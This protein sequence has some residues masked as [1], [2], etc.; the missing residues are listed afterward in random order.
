[1]ENVAH[2]LAGLLVARGVVAFRERREEAPASDAF[3]RW[4]AW[5]SAVANNVPDGDLILTPLSGGK[6]GYLLHHRGHTH[7][8]A[9]GVIL[10]LAVAL[11]ILAIARRRGADLDAADERWILGLGALGPVVHL[12]MDGLN[13]YGI[14]P[15][16]P[17]YDGWI[18]GDAV[19][20]VEPLLWLTAVPFLFA[21]ARTAPTRAVLILLT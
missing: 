9:V 8:L 19:F 14:H 4:A 12:F 10:G 5:A 2:A 18:Y 6:L 20:I 15:F 11:V 21:D 13:I 1:M 17:V 16:W 7:T 3:P